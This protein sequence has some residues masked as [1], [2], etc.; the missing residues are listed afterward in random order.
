MIKDGVQYSKLHSSDN[1]EEVIDFFYKHYVRDEPISTYLN[2]VGIQGRDWGA[3]LSPQIDENLS[4]VARDLADSKIVGLSINNELRESNQSFRKTSLVHGDRFKNIRLD[5]PIS[6]QLFDLQE[7]LKAYGV[8]KM[9]RL[10]NGVIHKEYRKRGI[11]KNLVELSLNCHQ[12]LYEYATVVATSNYSQRVFET[13]GFQLLG[14]VKY[15][16][17]IVSGKRI[18]NSDE[19]YKSCRCYI[20]IMNQTN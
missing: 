15:D 18:F 3:Y 1:K 16:D 20:K 10:S 5:Q 13:L 7:I 19:I 11:I 12:D 6:G 2:S 9:F 4:V 14:E 8:P 17:I